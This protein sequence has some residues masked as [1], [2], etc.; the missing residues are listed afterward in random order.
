MTSEQRKQNIE[1]WLHRQKYVYGLTFRILEDQDG[2]IIEFAKASKR[3][4]ITINRALIDQ[5]MIHIRSRAIEVLP[6][7]PPKKTHKKP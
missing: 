6:F 4:L 7:D 1:L 2:F 5:N 3:Q